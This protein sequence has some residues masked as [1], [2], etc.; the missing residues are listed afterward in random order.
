M[1]AAGTTE[2]PY[3]DPGVG[4]DAVVRV[5]GFEPPAVGFEGRRSVH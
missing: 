4:E 3:S 2:L 5:E 1:S